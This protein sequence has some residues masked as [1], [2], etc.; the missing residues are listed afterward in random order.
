[1]EQYSELIQSLLITMI[2]VLLPV[3][4]A[5]CVAWVKKQY[6]LVRARIP[7][8]QL[9]FLDALIAQFVL[10]AEQSGLSGQIANEGAAKKE[11]VILRLQEA[12]EKYGLKLDMNEISDLIEAKVYEAFKAN[13]LLIGG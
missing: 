11:W 2:Q 9:A 6:E 3:L 7:A 10:A 4:L 1:M 8:E 13:E 12:A 5:Y